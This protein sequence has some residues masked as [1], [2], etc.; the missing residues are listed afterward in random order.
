MEAMRAAAEPTRLRILVLCASGDVTVTELVRVLDQSQPRVSRHLKVL[1]HAGLLDRTPEGGWVFYGLISSGPLAEPARRLVDLAPLN[2]AVLK[3]DRERLARIKLERAEEAAQYFNQ[4]AQFWDR[5]RSLHVDDAQVEAAMLD[6]L[7]SAGI[8]NLLDIGTGT[9]RILELMADRIEH[10]QGVDISR[11]MLA[12]ARANLEKA[13]ATHIKVR[14]ANLAR[15][16][17]PSGSFDAITI[18]QVLHFLD[19]PASAIE[20]ASQVMTSDGHLLIADFAPHDLEDLRREHKHRRLGFK[21]DE[22]ESWCSAA[23]LKL[24]KTRR[25]PGNP[26]TVSIWL[27]QK[28]ETAVSFVP[29][30]SR[31][32]TETIQ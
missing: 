23:G 15:L 18:H 31:D 24:V 16:P 17:F 28:N 32:T 7:P 20:T 25:L 11:E 13:G 22:V 26:L 8:R 27:A 21:D 29:R 2:D 4:N 12:V 1:T 9:G 14:H 30:Y 3:R 5:L 10:G 6:L 19:D